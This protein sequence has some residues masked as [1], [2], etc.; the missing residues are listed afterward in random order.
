MEKFEIVAR[1]FRSL[2]FFLCNPFRFANETDFTAKKT[3]VEAFAFLGFGAAA[4]II[5]GQVNINFYDERIRR[6]IE[7][8]NKVEAIFFFTI[9]LTVFALLAFLGFRIFG[10]KASLLATIFLAMYAIAF[11]APV[12]TLLLILTTRLESALLNTTLVLVPPK[13]IIQFDSIEDTPSNRAIQTMFSGV[14]FAWNIYFAWLAWAALRALNKVGR[15]R[16][17]AGLIA[18]ILA[19]IAVAGVVNSAVNP[20]VEPLRPIWEWIFK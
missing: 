2:L 1:Y 14:L 11:T 7:V 19:L 16:A 3:K 20:S 6:V 9:A 5:A 17:V 18:T 15:L 13:R 10:G 4:S 12:L 8:T